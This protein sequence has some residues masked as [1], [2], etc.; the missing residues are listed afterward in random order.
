MVFGI[1]I[2]LG[3]GRRHSV[4]A[5]REAAEKAR[6]FTKV[7]QMSRQETHS[8]ILSNLEVLHI[9]RRQAI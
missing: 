8:A 4:L 3:Y 1:V 2:Y 5:R 7:C 6:E 9:T